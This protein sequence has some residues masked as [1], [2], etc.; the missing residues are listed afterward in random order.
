MWD[1][2]I[3][4]FTE[5]AF[6]RRALAGAIIL[7]V[8]AGPLGVFLMLRRMSLAGDAMS[9]A[10]LPG[11]AAGFLVSG[12]AVLP[13]TL[14]G[15]AAGIIVAL[16]SGLVSRNTVLREDIS[17]A[18]L[19]LISVALGVVLISLRGSNVDLL[20]VLFGTVLALDNDALLLI[21]AVAS[22]TLVGL[23]LIWRPLASCWK[24][25]ATR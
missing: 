22:L 17:L 7:A 3:A 13:M 12:L 21:G 8:S 4:P 14:G 11:A 24:P 9:H 15:F 10:I 23:A 16:L 25:S 2:F 18:A 1:L 20:H 19:Y 6:M 5:F